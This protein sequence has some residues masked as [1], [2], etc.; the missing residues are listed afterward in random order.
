MKTLLLLISLPYLA[1]TSY[2]QSTETT[3]A[4][5]NFGWI[6]DG[7]GIVFTAIRFQSDRKQ[8]PQA[9]IY[10]WDA[11]T[12]NIDL[13]IKDA[14]NPSISPD[15]S[16]MAYSAMTKGFMGN[17]DIYL[18]N[19]QTKTQTPLCIDTLRESSPSWSPNGDK[20]VYTVVSGVEKGMRH[21]SWDIYTINIKTK[22]KKQI[23]PSNGHKHFNPVWAPKGNKIV[24][25]L[26]KGDNRDQIY[27]TDENGSY[28]TNLT[29]DTTTHNYYP[30]WINDEILYTYD[31]GQQVII[32][33][34]TR[35][36]RMIADFKA[37]V[38]AY[39]SKTKKIAY[40]TPGSR[41]NPSD[42]MIY[43]LTTKTN[44]TVVSKDQT[45]KLPLH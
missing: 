3:T 21:A 32:N 17:M 40:L 28:H 43:D 22:E 29:N 16:T 31:P 44:V 18:Y 13:L 11:K 4:I 8:P 2:C 1:L 24:Y 35:E 20:I 26:E 15:G 33:P 39:N 9:A 12:Q 42:L 25:Y 37:F 45:S 30:S 27:I 41:A 34:E 10:K 6:P 36:K 23:S 19:F 7:S 5:V 14:G 38:A